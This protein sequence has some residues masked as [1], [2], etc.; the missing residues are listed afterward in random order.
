MEQKAKKNQTKRE[1][2]NK[3]FEK[4]GPQRKFS[5]ER[6]ANDAPERLGRQRSQVVDTGV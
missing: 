1:E 6:Y 3:N 2:K 5:P 4:P